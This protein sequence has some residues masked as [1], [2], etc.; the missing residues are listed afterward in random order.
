M[1]VSWKECVVDSSCVGWSMVCDRE[2]YGCNER[3]IKL[4]N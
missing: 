3:V 1:V 4:G 2:R